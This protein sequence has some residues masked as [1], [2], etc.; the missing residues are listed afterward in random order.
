[1]HEDVE[2]SLADPE[3]TELVAESERRLAELEEELKLAL[4]EKDPVDEKDVIV[5]IRSGVGGDEAAIWA[6]DVLRMLTRYA[7]SRGFKTELLSA[8][9]ERERRLQ[10]GRLR[11]QG[12]R[13]LLG[14]Q[15]RRRHA[16]G[17]ARSGDGVTGTDPH[18]DGDGRRHAG[19]RG[20]RGRPG[21]ERP[22]DRRLPLDRARR[23]ERQHDRLRRPHHA[24]ADRDRGRDAGREVAAPEQ[25]QGDARAAGAASTRP[26]ASASRRSSPPRA[27][28]RSARASGPRRSARTTIRTAGRPTTGSR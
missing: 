1:M 4:V 22:Q 3:L 7:E 20:D 16:P 27:G 6:G 12:R 5:E 8:E 28:R 11:R 2:A 10:G 13:R 14:V 25:G 21:R 15:V 23:P 9:R 19:G 18:L 24:P 26:S 17:P